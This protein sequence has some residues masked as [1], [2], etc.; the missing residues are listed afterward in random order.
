MRYLLIGSLVALVAGC[1]SANGGSGG[2]NAGGG[3]SSQFT[4]GC[5][6]APA[7]GTCGSCY[8]SCNCVNQNPAMCTTYCGSSAPPG[9]GGSTSISPPPGSGGDVSSV[10]GSP[11]TSTGGSP[12]TSTG[13]APPAGGGT[14]SAGGTTSESGGSTSTG[15]S[16]SI[17]G[18]AGTK[19]FEIN[20][21]TFQVPPGGEV[22]QCQNFKNPVGQD[23]AILESYST[24][25]PGSHHMFVFHGSSYDADTNSTATCSGTEFADYI[26]SAQ[27]PNQEILYPANVGRSLVGTDGLRILAHYLNS[28][29]DTLTGQVNVKFFY[30]DPSAVQYLAADIFLNKIDISVGAGMVTQSSSYTTPFEMKLLGAVSHM[31]KRGVGFVAKT[32]TGTTLYQGTTWD[33]PVANTFN[34]ALEIP[35]GTGI[36]WTCSYDNE[37]GMTLTFGESAATNEMCIFTGT[38]YSTDPNNKGTPMEDAAAF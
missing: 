11:T 14:T 23:I 9:S 24:M 5:T 10:G 3:S 13:G 34:P 32:S 18:P 29:N 35:S 25:A 19:E 27:T 6:S 33:E 21:A 4:P 31:H 15:G 7:C 1:S 2:E 28:T 30:A 22:Y 8:D 37:T 38:F 17:T 36:T 16:S 12:T 26:H 20:T